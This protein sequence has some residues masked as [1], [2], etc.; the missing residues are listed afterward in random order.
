LTKPIIFCADF[1]PNSG[2][3]LF[4]FSVFDFFEK[5]F[6]KNMLVRHRGTNNK[7]VLERAGTKWKV[8]IAISSTLK[9]QFTG[10]C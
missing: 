6:R 2:A 9:C 1:D 3:R 7:G 4:E 8:L 5:Y 10:K